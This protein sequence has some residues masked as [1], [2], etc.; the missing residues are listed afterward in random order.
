MQRKRYT[1][2]LKL[3]YDSQNRPHYRV[4][5]ITGTVVLGKS[6]TAIKEDIRAG[7]HIDE[8]T[9]EALA[10]FVEVTVTP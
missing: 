9:A 1:A 4:D 7:D 10:R 2:T 6:I 8:K 5:K 3:V